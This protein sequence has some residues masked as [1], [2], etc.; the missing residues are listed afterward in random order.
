MFSNRYI[1]VYSSA[2]VII[3]ALLLSFASTILQPYQQRN[4]EVEKMKDILGSAHITAVTKEIP[5]YYERYVIE[6]IVVDENGNIVASYA[7]GQ[8]NTGDIRAFSVNLKDE[9][10]SMEKSGKGHFPLYVIDKD[11]EKLYVIPMLGR[12]LWGPVWGTIALR[13]DF[14]SVA[15]V[16]FGHKSETPGLGAE[17]STLEFQQQFDNK[18][19]FN[20]NGEFVSVKVLKG[21]VKSHPAI[22]EIHGVDG[23]SGG[24]ITSDGTS[25]MIS[26]NLK[27]YLPFFQKMKENGNN[28][29]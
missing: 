26:S 22:S 21:G 9:L 20:E 13:D 5:S 8:F 4:L 6:E 14:S 11:G 2:M 23:I 19:I 1:F 27:N 17:I 10:R 28:G 29:N 3:V 7:Q 24:T 18:Q 12:G 15:G 25:D 16:T